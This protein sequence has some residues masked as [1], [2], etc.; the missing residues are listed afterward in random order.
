MTACPMCGGALAAWHRY[1]APP[2]GETAFDL[3]V[4]DRTLLRCETCGHM[5]SS[6]RLDDLYSGAY[7]DATYAGDKLAATYERIM[8]LPPEASDNAARVARVLAVAGPSGRAL[9]VGAG[10]GVFPARL[11]DAGWTVT[12][13]D[14]DARSAAHLRDVVGVEAVHAD[15]L[16]AELDGP[17]DLVTLNKVLEHVEDP[18]RMLARAREL[19]R[20]VYVELPDAEG[21]GAD[22]PG[23]EEFFIEHL[24]VFSMASLCL[25]AQRAGLTVRHAQRLREPS[26]KYTLVAFLEP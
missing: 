17:Y 4:Y 13:L 12:A 25:L 2:E 11:R 1:T 5:V 23:R 16:T 24:H 8:A 6:V 19:G 3:P 21:A 26:D 15:F 9:D 22:G 18:V 14:P 10:L 7:M 20:L